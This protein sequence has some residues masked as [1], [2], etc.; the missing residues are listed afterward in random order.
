[1]VFRSI[2]H[3]DLS[4]RAGF[5]FAPPYSFSSG[6]DRHCKRLVSKRPIYGCLACR[7]WF[8]EADACR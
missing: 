1:M 2:A 8:L 3:S 5:G 6:S 7:T 4:S